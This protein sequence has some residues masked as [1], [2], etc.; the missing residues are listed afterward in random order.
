MNNRIILIDGSYFIFY[1]F[2]ALCNWVKMS[3]TE[4][5]C[6]VS[7]KIFAAKFAKICKDTILK[8]KKT[9]KIGNMNEIY[10]VMDCNRSNIW[11]NEIYNLY[12]ANRVQKNNFDPDVFKYMYENV[13]PDVSCKVLQCDQAEADDIIGTLCK[14]IQDSEIIVIADD[15]DYLQLADERICLYNLK[16]KC[17]NERVMGN[18]TKDL[19]Y[20]ILVGDKADNIPSI[21]TEAKAKKIVD[22]YYANENDIINEVVKINKHQE[23][24]LNKALIDMQMIPSHIITNI[25]ECYNLSSTCF[26]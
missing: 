26:K 5:E 18:K 6:K 1:R 23:Y 15:N 7:D 17:I 11:R 20:K 13:L 22:M 14:Y 21:F 2:Y 12:K 25:V 24:Q 8:L 9:H 16:Q 3:K 19:F 4:C 10:F